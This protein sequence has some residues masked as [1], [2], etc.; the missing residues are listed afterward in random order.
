MA[1]F[2][3]PAAAGKTPGVNTNFGQIPS[4]QADIGALANVSLA[5]KRAIDSLAGF[6]GKPTSRAVTFD[7]LVNLGLIDSTAVVSQTGTTT[8]GSGT[9]KEI[10]T[11]GPGIT[12]GPITITGEL[13]VEWN[14]GT[15]SGLGSHITNVGGT[16][17][18]TGFLTS[19]VQ[20]ITLG[21][22]LVGSPNPITNTGTIYARWR[23][24]ECDQIGAG[25]NLSGGVLSTTVVECT[26]LVTGEAD[27]NGA[28]I[29]VAD[30]S[31]QPIVVPLS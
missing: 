20:K 3:K 5:L 30:A 2:T 13:A 1:S 26:L 15:V 16:L 10:G 14:A 31:N 7:D 25:L 27:A 18:A 29:F 22:G 23:A 17:N 11:V 8:L 4:P 12:G 9:V 6:A 24:D 19:A 28:P 21:A